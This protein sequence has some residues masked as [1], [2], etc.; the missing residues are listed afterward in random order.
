MR[1]LM[2]KTCCRDPVTVMGWAPEGYGPHLLGT[3]T[4]GL[5]DVG[6]FGL[7]GRMGTAKLK[8]LVIIWS[9]TLG[10]IPFRRRRAQGWSC[11]GIQG[12]TGLPAGI[13]VGNSPF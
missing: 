10:A 8:P 3:Q 13:R 4:V 9:Q 2:E 7:S 1:K 5:M 12:N 11:E 6:S